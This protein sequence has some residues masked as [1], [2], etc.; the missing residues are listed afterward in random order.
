MDV[1]KVAHHG[2]R[3]SSC[4]AFL[5]RV[6]PRVAVMTCGPC[7]KVR[8]K[9]RPEPGYDRGASKGGAYPYTAPTAR[10]M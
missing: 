1:L 9:P 3:S 4:P 5:D 2:S 7:E 10:G 6:S 8:P